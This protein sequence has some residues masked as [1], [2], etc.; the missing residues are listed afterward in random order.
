MT[1]EEEYRR[2]LKDKKVILIGPAKSSEDQVTNDLVNSYDVVV[3]INDLHK[4]QDEDRFRTDVI[5]CDGT[6]NKD[7]HD[8]YKSSNLSFIK[9]VYPSSEWFYKS[10]MESSIKYMK[11]FFPQKILTLSEETYSEIKNEIA[12]TRPNLLVNTQP[13][14]LLIHVPL[15]ETKSAIFKKYH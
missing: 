6:L 5:Y 2:F 7:R 11:R 4:R 3:R 15:S 9:N 10:R 14:F 1:P 8:S 13:T 12:N